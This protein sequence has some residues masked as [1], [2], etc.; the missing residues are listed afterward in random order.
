LKKI[1]DGSPAFGI[2]L[3]S[4]DPAIVEICAI[5]GYDWVSLTL[6]HA[7]LT[8]REVA[9]LQRAADL[10][11]IS[12]L[13]H[14]AGPDDPRILTLL[15]EGVGGVVAP[16]VTKPAEVEAL[17]R[18]SRFPPI[19]ER[20]GAGV[21][22]RS[23]YGAQDYASYIE[24]SDKLV[25]VGISIEDVAGVED[26]DAILGV[27]GLNLAYVGLHDLTLSI[28]RPGEYSH[29][30]I[31]D[32]IVHVGA[33]AKKHGVALALS[34]KGFTIRELR[35][36]GASMIVTNPAGEYIALLDTLSA[37]VAAARAELA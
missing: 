31:R 8:T 5:A 4:P 19:G 30:D 36:F 33:C 26:A 27:R 24:R 13:V 2:A 9:N 17:V 15:D 23:D 21:T 22:R 11:G 6:E 16:H 14:V 25:A 35:D 3:R 32:A 37:R 10:R 1:G 7:S 34:E 28:G 12:T 20:G 29:P 18:A